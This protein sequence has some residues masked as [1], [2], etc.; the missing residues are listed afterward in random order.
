MYSDTLEKFPL[1]VKEHYKIKIISRTLLLNCLNKY[2]SDLWQELF[3]DNFKFDSW[4]KSDSRLKEFKNLSATWSQQTP[5]RNYFERRQAL[6]EIDVLTAMALG[7]S[8]G[9]LILIYNVQ[10][11]VLQQN[12]NEAWYDKKGNIVFTN[13]K[14][15][16]GVGLD[17]KEW[18]Q[19]KDLKD[20]EI[21]Q[22]TIDRKKSE[23]YGGQTVTYYA[24]FDKCDRVEDYKTAWAHFEK[25][26]NVEPVNTTN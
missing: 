22:H 24:P 2:Y 5:L 15:L 16:N 13:S 14:S 10:F 3:N 4:S 20:G 21:H 18:E 1:G 6:I 12:E 9:E 11:P 19:I 25:I 17:R 8:C 7:L 26:F 23:L